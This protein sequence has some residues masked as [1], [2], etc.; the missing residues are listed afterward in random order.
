MTCA[1]PL[2]NGSGRIIQGRSASKRGES[3]NHEK[4]RALKCEKI[5]QF[6][7]REDVE[8]KMEDE[9]G[10]LALPRTIKRAAEDQC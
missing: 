7:Q 8:W 4:D 10:V 6:P 5:V 2:H 1:F 9:M 3:A